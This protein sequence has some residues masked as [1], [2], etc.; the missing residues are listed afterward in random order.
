MGGTRSTMR[1][2]RVAGAA[3]AVAV[4]LTATG[5]LGAAPAEGLARTGTTAIAVPTTAV[6][7]ADELYVTSVYRDLL[8]RAPD[9]EGLTHWV[10]AL[11]AG[12]PRPAVALSITSSDEYRTSLIVDAY[13]TFLTRSPEPAGQAAWL[14][15]MRAGMTIDALETGFASSDEAYLRASSSAGQ[16]V[17]WL[18][19][20][21]LGRSASSSE[22]GWWVQMMGAG[23]SRS[24]VSRGFLL[25]DEH[26]GSIVRGQ[27]L[28]LLGRATDAGGLATWVQALRAGTRLESVAAQ[29]LSSDEYYARATVSATQ[30]T[31]AA[32]TPATP[33]ASASP[34][35]T[36][37]PS[38]TAA[39]VSG[40]PG[41][42]NTGVPAGRSLVPSGS[43]TVTKDNTVLDGLD[44]AGTVTIYASNVQV[45]NSRV[46]GTGT[47]VGI[48][49]RSGSATITDTEITGFENGIAGNGWTATRVNIHGST[50]D[51]VKLGSSV[52]LEASWIHDLTPAP[53]AHSDGAQMQ[54]GLVDVVVRGNNFALDT[55]VNA[56]L[57]LAP[58]LGPSS[59]GPV[60]ITGNWLD[61]GNFTVFCVDG[62]NGQYFTANISITNNRFGT[63]N[64]YGPLNVN[65]PVTLTGNVYDVSGQ[66]LG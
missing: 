9:A 33:T 5:T 49:V 40:K 57:F 34:T 61:G 14:E 60:T 18:Y 17:A 55:G 39:P 66:A 28:S 41:A 10:A 1:A 27:Y 29:L 23:M 13:D 24:D 11:R 54:S 8:G 26:L 3:L 63:N 45:K 4:V 32:P 51:G 58:D 52:T 50:G 44:I 12:T 6:Q 20:S 7:S 56:A 42:S 25:S 31:G 38:A 19:S 47:D 37:T 15:L 65:V 36:A 30:T 21:M 43:I 22:I 46:T 35:A 2:G 64:R 59:A 53:G 16:W 62:N 48:W